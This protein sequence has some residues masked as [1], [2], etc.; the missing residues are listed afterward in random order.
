MLR[1]KRKLEIT[2]FVP[3]ITAAN[4]AIAAPISADGVLAA[5]GASV[6][7]AATTDSE[8]EASGKTGDE[9]MRLLL[10]RRG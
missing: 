8:E 9:S 10:R 2:P 5:G 4:I 3:H 6:A 1:S 7:A